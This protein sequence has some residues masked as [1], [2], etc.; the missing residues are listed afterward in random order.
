M[1]NLKNSE[2]RVSR[3]APSRMRAVRVLAGITTRENRD[4]LPSRRANGL[5]SSLSTAVWADGGGSEARADNEVSPKIVER[6][7]ITVAFMVSPLDRRGGGRG[8]RN[9]HDRG[10]A[11]DRQP[12]R[13]QVGRVG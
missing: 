13:D 1:L 5:I 4:C 7:Q 2:P 12:Q 9:F 8:Q 6:T 3:C 10:A 11:Q